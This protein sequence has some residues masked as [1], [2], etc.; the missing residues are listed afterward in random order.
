MVVF[1]R[2]EI[3]TVDGAALL[4]SGSGNLAIF[5][6]IGARDQATLRYP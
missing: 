6:A 2:R 5:S 1:V 3:Q 4:G